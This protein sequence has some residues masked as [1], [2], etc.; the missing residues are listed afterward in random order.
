M[1]HTILSGAGQKMS[2]RHFL[3]SVQLQG[4]LRQLKSNHRQT[5]FF[6]RGLTIC[7]PFDPT[8]LYTQVFLHIQPMDL[9]TEGPVSRNSDGGKMKDFS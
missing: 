4:A 6:E 3:C 9:D 8:L 7:L 2:W 1:Q 5:S